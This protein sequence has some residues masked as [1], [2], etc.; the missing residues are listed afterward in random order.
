MSVRLTEEQERAVSARGQIIVSASAGS[1]KTFVMIE[2]LVSLIL[3]GG[4]VRNIL[5][6]TFTNKAAA[7][8]RER[9]RA[10]L[11][12]GIREGG[13]E[14]RARL[15]EQLAALPLAEISTIHA[16]C[17]RL[18]R[19]Y[20]YAA[21][22]QPAFRIV[23]PDDAEGAQLAA[24]AMD[25]VFEDA[26]AQGGGFYELLSVYF[27]RKRDTALRGI[28]SRIYA[29]VRGMSD[30]RRKLADMGTADMFDA[31]CSALAEGYRVRAASV[32]EGLAARA[33]LYAA[34]GEKA[35][36]LAGALVSAAE[37]LCAADSLF[38]MASAAGALAPFARMPVKQKAAADE[39]AAL[40]YLSGAKKQIKELIDA[41]AEYASPEEERAR[42][43]D[44]RA[45]SGALGALVLAYDEA[46]TREKTEAGVLDYNDLEHYALKLLQNEDIR[47]ALREKYRSVFVDEYQ[48]V[49]PIQEEI[50]SCLSGDDVFLVGDAKQA[51][52]GFRGSRSAFFEK[53]AETLP[54]SLVLSSNFR[55][56]PAVLRAVNRVFSPLFGR[57][58]PMRGGERYGSYE[59]G[60][61]FYTL[62]AAAREK[63]PPQGVYSVLR[64]GAQA[65]PDPLADAVVRLVEAEKGRAWYDADA[66][67]GARE[68]RVD[69]GD[70]A[71]LT[72]RRG[73]E[74]E[75]IVRALAERG[76]PVT[77][78]AEVNVCDF[79]EARLILDW[80]SYLDD[81]EQDIPFVSALLSAVGGFTDADLAHVRYAADEART[82]AGEPPFPDFRAACDFYCARFHDGICERFAAFR[83]KVRLLRA[84]GRIRTAAE[85]INE[86]LASGLEAQ[87]AAKPGGQAR[88]ARVRRLAAEGETSDTHAFL[89]RLKSTGWRVGFSESGGDGAVKVVTMHASKGLEYPVVILAGMDV[90]F[91]G[92]AE[93]EEVLF[94][95]EFLAAPKSYDLSHKY[96]YTTVLRRACAARE[97]EETRKEEKNLLYVGMTRARDRL[98]VLFSA[99]GKDGAFFPESAG[100]MADLIDR[101]AFSDLAAELPENERDAPPRRA[102]AHEPDAALL[103]QILRTYCMPYAYEAST[104][105]PVKSSATALM[106]EGAAPE[107]ASSEDEERAARLGADAWSA[108]GRERAVA[109]GI[110][111]HA[112]LQYADFSADPG[113]EIARL[114]AAGQ[115]H[116]EQAELLDVQRLRGI[117]AVPCI[118]RLRGAHIL[119][120]QKFLVRLQADELLETEAVDE[121]VFQ[122]AIDLLAEERDGFTVIDYKFSALDDAQLKRRYAVQIALYKK[123]VARVMRTDERTVRAYIV[124][125]AR[126][127][128][129]PM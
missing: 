47:R 48:D 15:K 9:L 75:T 6:V 19:T 74:A 105:L 98:H 116:P 28:V 88:L 11:L 86:L 17:G 78:A 121:I 124:D 32:R 24:R 18:V 82:A 31:A 102:L 21:G 109:R 106:H 80:L 72:R 129:I 112:Y 33:A 115:L 30:Y 44:A 23:S 27:R 46:Y 22:V 43:E 20:F 120:E 7:Q 63:T 95:D 26:Y 110:A 77:S 81:P 66:S 53:K 83:E 128:E 38:S 93:R 127:R 52:Y 79:F 49:N 54:Q 61:Y 118:A 103:A 69:Y 70:I 56:S 119:R 64:A 16:F 111:Y 25:G 104:R 42:Y 8:M 108:A 29:S 84:H 68:K 100:C 51:I 57:Y 91:H 36:A 90:P 34:L 99:R 62:P 97:A 89:A 67:D 14:V 3:G 122:G 76:I 114:A 58:V 50:L 101:A 71:V 13:E 123:A 59:G 45:R 65:Q 107:G 4:D 113:E 60:V 1:G 117:L 5:A 41:L 2:R 55:S 94:S 10:A 125:L 37:T 126:C 92:G 40:A 96:S 87:I 12:K 35:A 85:C 73:D 39:R